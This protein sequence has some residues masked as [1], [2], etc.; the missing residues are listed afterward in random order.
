MLDQA[1]GWLRFADAKATAVLSVSGV[2]GGVVV[3]R[4]PS[5]SAMGQRPWPAVLA[6][7]ALLAVATA[8]VFALRALWPR[9]WT[10]SSASLL[11]FQH[12]ARAYA[13]RPADFVR[14]CAET[15]AQDSR[16]ATEIYQQLWVNSVLAEQKYARVNRALM[17]LLAG[18]VLTVTTAVIG[19]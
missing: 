5:W 12:V 10:R 14:N 9:T 15:V 13:D 7:L 17:A 18:L 16:L 3:A 6:S 8:G 11:H 2:L 1:N 4:Y 19:A